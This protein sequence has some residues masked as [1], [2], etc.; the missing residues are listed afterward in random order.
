MKDRRN[1]NRDFSLT[2]DREQSKAFQ[3]YL[4]LLP[5]SVVRP[6]EYELLNGEWRFEFDPDDRGLQEGWYLGHEFSGTATWPGSV[7]GHLTNSH[8]NGQGLPWQDKVVAWYEREFTVPERWCTV[9]SCPVQ[10]T[11]GACGYETRVWLNGHLLQTVEGEDAHFGGYTSFSYELPPD[12]LQPVNR[13]TVRIKNSLDADIPRGKQESRIY[14]R[15]G[16]WYQTITG[17]VRSI[18]MEP[19]ERNRLRSRLGV[20]SRVSDRVVEFNLTTRIHDPGLYKLRLVVGPCGGTKPLEVKEYE[21]PLE[22]GEKQQRVALAL[23]GASLWSPWKPTLYHLVAQLTGPDGRVSQIEAHFGL[24]KVETRGHMVYLNNKA[25]YL[26]GILY[27]PG[28]ATFE[29]MRQH[30]LSMKALGCNLVRVHIAGIDPRIYDLADEIGMLLWVEVPSP[31]D[32]SHASRQNHWDELRR[33]LVMIDSHPSVIIVSLYNE[34]WGAQ[35]IATSYETRRY[36]AKTYDFMRLNY[37]QFLVVDNDGWNHVS[38]EG[39]IKSDL[40]TAHLYTADLGQ[41]QKL[42]DRLVQGNTRDVAAHPLVVG[43]PFFYGGQ[44]PLIVSEWGGFGFSNYGGPSET[45][46]KAERIRAFKKELRRR[47][48]GG[49][50]YTQAVSI[51]EEVNGLIEPET[52]QL[53]VPPRLLDSS[54]FTSEG[55]DKIPSNGSGQRA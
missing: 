12:Y 36:I 3:D 27:Q 29:Q 42:L 45:A 54:E 40:L 4:N 51:E 20:F 1:K 34:D 8:G 24:R 35:D 21:L 22:T 16:I 47:L 38:M 26:D 14:K 43:D 2:Q 55:T 5:R 10:V 23:K 44:A 53:L 6:T 13:L 30:M 9:P 49:D 18:W 11:F 48:I 17:A 46:E 39:R 37:P 41:W 33:M 31:H 50:V 15:G 32:S 7:E 52:G 28:T 19:V 25:L